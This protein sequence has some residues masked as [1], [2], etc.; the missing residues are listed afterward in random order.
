MD[1]PLLSPLTLGDLTLKNRVVLAPLTRSR[2]GTE[3]MA[4]PLMAEYYAQR[5]GAGLLISEATVISPQGIGWINSPGIYSPAQAES[6]QQVT[7]AVHD[8]GSHIFLQLWHCG[9]ASH[10]AFHGGAL[11][12][13][14]SAIALNGDHIHTPQG[15]QA[16]ETPRALTTEEVAQ[17]VEDYGQAAERAKLAGFD[18]VEIH[19]ANGYLID[20]FLQTKTNHR[21]DRYG[22]SLE[23]RYRFLQEILDRV[24]QVWPAHR[25]GVRLSPNGVFNDMG[26]PEYR[27]IFLY[28]AQQLKGYG[29]GYL[30]LMD[31]LAFGFHNLGEPMT[32]ADFREIYPGVIMGNCGYD[33]ATAEAAI[34]QG[35]ADLIAF[36]RSFISNPD[37]VDRFAQGWP[38]NPLSD[39]AGWYSFGPEGYTDFAP[40]DPA[41]SLE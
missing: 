29:L 3:R 18:G 8:R 30:H 33:Q 16:Y 23:N 40:Y 28:V 20:Q 19:G 10:S 17:V 35:Q 21:D 13:A 1:S 41:S 22:G 25:V 34:A 15:K 12:V 11:P 39:M 31:G 32:L 9:R 7:Q 5:S 38:L 6:W 14:P 24:L 36:G 26:S 27:E 4:N 2:A 37:L